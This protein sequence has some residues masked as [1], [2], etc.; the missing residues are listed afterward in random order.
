MDP[1]AARVYFHPMSQRLPRALGGIT[2]IV[3]MTTLLGVV[4]A[5]AQERELGPPLHV[6]VMARSD[7]PDH[8]TSSVTLDLLAGGTAKVTS[9]TVD[10]SMKSAKVEISADDPEFD[11]IAVNLA[12]LPTT[13]ARVIGCLTAALGAVDL[14]TDKDALAQIEASGADVLVVV[15]F[16]CL[17]I[18]QAIAD[19]KASGSLRSAQAPAPGCAISPL[20]IKTTTEKTDAGYTMSATPN[21]KMNKKKSKLKVKCKRV[22]S[23]NIYTIKPRKK[24]KSLRSAVGKNL[25]V[26]IASP[27]S[28]TKALTM[29]VAF[30]AP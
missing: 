11:N 18:A 28:A 23:K 6:A 9:P 7:D 12:Q 14:G 20:Q 26:G 8:F 1:G 3:V 2:A 29:K 30:K 10:P 19:L 21:I 22:G 17:L 16:F 15:I 13:G 5:Q 25:V 27:S 4:P 24:G